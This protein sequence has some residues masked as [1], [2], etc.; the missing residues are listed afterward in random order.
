MKKEHQNKVCKIALDLIEKRKGIKLGQVS[1]PDEQEHNEQAVDTLSEYD[2]GRIVMEH[3]TIESYIEQIEDNVRIW[4]L[5]KPLEKILENKLSKPGHYDLVVD[6]GATKGAKNTESINNNLIYWIKTTAPLLKIGS[7]RT[8]PDHYRK[9]KPKGV[10]FE[11]SLYRWEGNGGKFF[12]MLNCPEDVEAQR[13]ERI[14]VAFESKCPKLAK[15]KQDG[16]ISVLLLELDDISLGNPMSVAQDVQEILPKQKY[17][18][19]EI[20]L[21]R[22]ELEKWEVFV[23]KEGNTLFQDVMEAGP[24]YYDVQID[25]PR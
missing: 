25:K 1:F 20:Y 18:P 24:Y 9:E 19:D 12:I 4:R 17:I 7:P 10:P 15:T 21:I 2:G 5:L 13:K 8:A 23:L 6:V 11:V 16:D 22:T 14:K 3:T